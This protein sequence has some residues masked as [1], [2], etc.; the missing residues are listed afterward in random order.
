[1]K[2]LKQ[3]AGPDLEAAANSINK[4]LESKYIIA[5]TQQAGNFSQGMVVICSNPWNKI[6]LHLLCVF[7]V[8]YW[9]MVSSFLKNE[10]I[11]PL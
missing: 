5:S 4:D 2:E 11:I 6:P 7:G 1:M 10:L 9:G 8:N 3:L